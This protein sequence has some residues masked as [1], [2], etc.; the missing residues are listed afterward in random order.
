MN[1]LFC[2]LVQLFMVDIVAKLQSHEVQIWLNQII[3]FISHVCVTMIVGV[4]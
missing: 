3:L 4:F 1:H 2:N